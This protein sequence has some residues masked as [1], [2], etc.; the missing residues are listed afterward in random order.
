M[1]IARALSRFARAGAAGSLVCA[2]LAAL[3]AASTAQAAGPRVLGSGTLQDPPSIRVLST[4]ADGVE[5]EFRLPALAV[6]DLQAAGE[7]FQSLAIPTGGENGAVGDP[8]VP[9]FAR[10][11]QIP[12][13]ADVQV[14]A[15][16]QE[17]DEYSG[18]KVIPVQGEAGEAFAYDLAAYSRNDWG[19]TPSAAVGSPALMRGLARRALDLCARSVQPG[20]REDPGRAD[21]AGFGQLRRGEHGNAGRPDSR[22][23][24]ESFDRLYRELV[25]NYDRG[26]RDVAARLLA[27]DLPEQR[28]RR[29][30]AA[31]AR[32]PGASARD[33]STTLATTAETGTTTTAIKAYIQNAYN[34]WN[35]PPEYIVLAGDADGSYRHPDLPRDHFGTAA[36]A[37]TPTPSSTGRD[38]LADAHIGR[39]SFSNTTE[40][41][42]IVTKIVGYEST[43]YMA[44]DTAW[45]TPRLPGRGPE[46]LRL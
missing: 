11:L 40:L 35:P 26:D 23:I 31:A 37:T 42:T 28:H 15:T 46:R 44:T 41:E 17:T 8:M 18:I 32:R 5:L 4:R 9:I 2:F 22:P 30:Q 36:R 6:E 10:L 1:S 29:Q 43:P 39:L 7:T 27:R 19:N 21:D 3:V 20:R 38:I 16:I 12:D 24:P 14:Q 33:S 34:T 25:V 13:R 45:Y